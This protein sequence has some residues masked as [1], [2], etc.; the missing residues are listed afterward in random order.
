[1]NPLLK[2]KLRKVTKSNLHIYQTPKPHQLTCFHKY[3][4]KTNLIPFF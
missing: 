1:M 2:T 3:V 4:Y